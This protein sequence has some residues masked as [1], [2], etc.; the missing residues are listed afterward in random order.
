MKIPVDKKITQ[1]N[2]GDLYGTMIKSFNLDLISNAGTWRTAR[3]LKT[4]D[5]TI[6]GFGVPTAIEQFTVGGAT[7]IYAICGAKIFLTTNTA[8][9][10]GLDA[11]TPT[12]YTAKGDLKVFNGYLYASG[13]DNHI[14]KLDNAGTWTTFDAGASSSS[15]AKLLVYGKRMYKTHLDT[16]VISW[17]TSD[18]VRV[19]GN[20]NAL[21][22]SGYSAGNITTLL[23]SSGRIWI[24]TLNTTGR[25]SM[26]EWD[27]VLEDTVTQE[28]KLKSNGVLAGVIF[29]D[30]PYIM[31]SDGVLR[32]Y[33]GG[34]F[35][36]VARLPLI[37][38]NLLFS[39]VPSN[40]LCFIQ[41]NGM[42]VVDREILI[43]IN[44][45]LVRS[46]TGLNLASG[47]WAYNPDLGLYHKYSYSLSEFDNSGYSASDILDFGQHNTYRVGAIKNIRLPAN[48][49]GDLLVGAEIYSTATAKKK[50]MFVNHTLGTFQ[51]AGY[52][53]T[54]RIEAQNKKES[55]NEL[56]VIF[57]K[58]ATSTDKIVLKQRIVED[59]PLEFNATWTDSNTFTGTATG[60]GNYVIGDEVEFVQG[61]GSGLCAHIT[62]ITSLSGTYTVDIDETFSTATGTASARLSKW[63]KLGSVDY[64]YGVLEQIKEFS[65]N[66]ASPFVQLKVWFTWTGD[67]EMRE[68][69]LDNQKYK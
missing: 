35:Q 48:Y 45:D 20:P 16:Q 51:K 30:V 62:A 14:Y 23:A 65:I 42:E 34:Q 9:S 69:I 44:G 11:A 8:G 59:D 1:V 36:E 21:Q 46:A 41:H 43:N 60:M 56:S 33:S 22:L 28:Y 55:W 61:V 25:G 57:K 12:T 19:V 39:T 4:A 7:N 6:E 26:F 58:L 66:K 47:V 68:L 31:D 67:G 49:D 29:N 53:I 54:P 2:N 37:G 40:D 10:W 15:L 38:D 24:G 3:L 17:D 5:E 27:G 18:T 63:Q 32:A 64:T 13:D 52:F 50:A